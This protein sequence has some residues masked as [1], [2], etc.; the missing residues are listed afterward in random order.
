MTSF[1]VSCS[2]HPSHAHVPFFKPL[3]RC[4]NH[5]KYRVTIRDT[6]ERN[7]R[8]QGLKKVKWEKNGRG[9]QSEMEREV[10]IEENEQGKTNN[11]KGI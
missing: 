2:P 9:L 7:S 1:P 3:R 11:I 10:S 4:K 6:E 5:S 8:V